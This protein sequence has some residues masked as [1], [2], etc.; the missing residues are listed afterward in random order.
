MSWFQR[1]KEGITTSTK[2]KKETP[3]VK[4]PDKSAR[5][6]QYDAAAAALQK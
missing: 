2:E 3:E 6:A 5:R 4:S 1:R